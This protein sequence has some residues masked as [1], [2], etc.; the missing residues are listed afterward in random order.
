MTTSGK[1]ILR[2]LLYF[3][4]FCHPLN[5]SELF[6]LTGTRISWGEFEMALNEL[7][8]FK[9]VGI[10]SEYVFIRKNDALLTQRVNKLGQSKRYNRISRIISG[11]IYYHPFVRG[12]FISGSLSKGAFSK[13]DDID[14]FIISEVGRVWLCK[15]LLMLFKKVFLLNSKRFFCINYFIDTESLEIPEKNIFTAAEI[16]FLI[17]QRNSELCEKFFA[18]NDWIQTFFPNFTFN[19]TGCSKARHPFF[20]RFQ[21]SLLRG[22]LGDKLDSFFMEVYRKRSKKKFGNTDPELFKINFKCEKNVAKYH[23]SGFQ[24]LILQSYS[25]KISEFQTIHKLDLSI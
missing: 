7:I 8:D 25:S 23:P 14:F 12:V 16:A 15:A 13:K 22:R 20:K 1:A 3:D 21:E 4:I 9:L 2:T 17:P 19:L 10:E 5:K 18:S 11:L 24:H 6:R